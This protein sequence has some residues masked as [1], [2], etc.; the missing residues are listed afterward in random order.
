MMAA[1]IAYRPP[2]RTP[3]LARRAGGCYRAWVTPSS[4][5]PHRAP[6]AGMSDVELV[7]ELASGREE[8]L[9]ELY[10]RFG[11]LLLAVG[12]RI[13]KDPIEAEDLLHDV[14]VEAW[15]RASDFDPARGGVRAWLITRM[16]S[17]ALDRCK[18]PGRTR[19]TVLDER[20]ENRAAEIEVAD[21]GDHARLRR[22]VGVLSADQRAVVEC[23]YFDGLS[24]SEIAARL[25]IPVGTVKSRMAAGL[26]KL[27]AELGAR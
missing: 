10:D 3:T 25:G 13:L 17:R 27:R 2:P 26:A 12:V 15:R 6:L 19:A 11:G 1:P 5:P 14:F 7:V 16:R 21:G 23:A 20:Y 9:G 8:A 24:S 18:S 22:A 4:L